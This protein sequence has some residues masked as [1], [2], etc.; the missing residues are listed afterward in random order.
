[1][2]PDRDNPVAAATGHGI[3]R[4]PPAGPLTAEQAW[5]RV[6]EAGIKVMRIPTPFA[7]GRVNTYLLEDDP[8]T[9]IDSGPNS[10]KALDE[11]ERQL[12]GLGHRVEDLGLI[13]VSHQHIDH[14]GLVEILARRS[15]AEVAA[16][17]IL[18]PALARFSEDADLDDEHAAA[19][20][21]RHGIPDEMVVAL[22]SVS[23]S[24]R[25]WGAAAEVT[26]PLRDGEIL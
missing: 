5:Q 1:M 19:L 4:R 23:Q 10:G 18:A 13:F 21:R 9:L 8:L 26:R 24:F 20:M 22:R 25:G 7:V 15:G 12:E 17:D 16:I 2:N 14:T 3:A 11:L 6:A